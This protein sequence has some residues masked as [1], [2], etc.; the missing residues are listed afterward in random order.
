VARLCAEASDRI[1]KFLLPVIRENLARGGHITLS[2]AVVASWA[3]YAEGVD[4]QGEPIEIV[5]QLK[6]PLT[7]SARRQRE[8]PVA[9]IANRDVFGDLVDDERFASAYISTLDSLHSQGA[10]AT[11]ETLMAQLPREVPAQLRR[12]R[13][14]QLLQGETSVCLEEA[15]ALVLRTLTTSLFKLRVRSMMRRSRSS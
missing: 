12:S 7:A 10:R 13:N 9:F 11:L 5:D 15:S 6:E 2:A 1:P 4:D 14:R 8:D 3:R